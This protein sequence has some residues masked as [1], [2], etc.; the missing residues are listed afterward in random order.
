MAV[1][2]YE[3]IFSNGAWNINNPKDVDGNGK[4]V[5]LAERIKENATIGAKLVN[6]ILNSDA[7]I[8]MNETL[9][10]GDKTILDNIV[11]THENATGTINQTTYCPLT[12]ANGTNYLICVDNAGTLQVI[13]E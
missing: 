7:K 10:S 13:A 6:V 3:R 5:I 1:Y 2:T 11:T 12:S 4:S 9:S 8:E